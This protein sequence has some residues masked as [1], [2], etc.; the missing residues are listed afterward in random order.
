LCVVSIVWRLVVAISVLYREAMRLVLVLLIIS[1]FRAAAAERLN[2]PN[3]VVFLADDHGYLDSEVYGSK[4]VRTPNMLRLA[5]EGIVFTRVFVA[6]PSCAP[7]RAALLTGLMPARNGAE[8]NHAKPKAELKKLPAYF[9]ELGY[10]VAA[11][12]KVSHYNH[13]KD[14]GFDHFAHDTFHDHR[15]IPAALKWLRE[16]EAKKPLCLFVGSNWPHVPW[17]QVTTN[18]S[19]VPSF[20][21]TTPETLRARASYFAAVEKMDSELGQTYDISREVLGTNTLFIHTSD[22]GA[23]FPF[24][25]WNC[26]DSGIRTSFLAVWPGVIK[27]ASR[28]DAMVS[29][30]DILPTLVE[31]AG[32]TSPKNID[33]R[34]FLEALR[35]RRA[36]H[37]EV[38]F[39]TH[40]ADGNMN[41]YPIRALR[42]ADWKY[43]LNLHPEYKFTTH[44]DLAHK[45]ETRPGYWG[46]YWQSWL[47]A[48]KSNV[49]AAAIVKA[50]HQ[51]PAEEL[52]ELSADPY[53][54]TNLANDPKHS[55]MK[56]QLRAQLENWM[57]DQGDRQTVFGEPKLLAP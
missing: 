45:N 33:G 15:A 51:R 1:F 40:S 49:S 37:R 34:S 16:R 52:Y 4:E 47:E 53:E 41:V 22:H 28:T 5:R 8:P 14:Y 35:Q 18:A 25:K 19:S 6:S 7:S 38:I 21:V 32:G 2:P 55:G 23:Q 56:A 11:F 27:S 42:T 17:P 31:A 30:I 44:I 24:G 46:G 54:Q 50:Y 39:T 43:I 9:K 10:E 36:S 12:G 57:R 29:W 48:A 3:I 13:T 26:Y 20:L